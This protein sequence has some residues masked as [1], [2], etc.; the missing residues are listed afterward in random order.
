M[1]LNTNFNTSAAIVDGKL[2]LAG[3][4]SGA[5]EAH[6]LL[7]RN[8]IVQQATACAQRAATKDD[9]WTASRPIAKGKF[10]AGPA[11]AVGIE[12]YCVKRRAQESAGFVTITWSQAITITDDPPTPP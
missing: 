1:P 4:T 10:K 11:L 7:S 8:F 6:T 12:T 5:D 3:T 2:E 9:D